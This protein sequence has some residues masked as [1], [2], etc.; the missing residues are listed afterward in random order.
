M[1]PY[2][3]NRVCS[4]ERRSQ[5]LH[6]RHAP[7]Q[8]SHSDLQRPRCRS[9]VGRLLSY[10]YRARHWLLRPN[11]SYLGLRQR[12]SLARRLPHQAHATHLLH[13]LLHGRAFRTQ[14]FRRRQPSYLEGQSQRKARLAQRKGD[15]SQRILGEPSE[16]VE[17]CRRRFQDREAEARAKG[18]QA[19]TEAQDHH[20]R[21]KKNKEENRRKHSKAGDKKP[22]AA[23]KEAILSQKIESL[24]APLSVTFP[25]LHLSRVCISSLPLVLVSHQNHEFS[26]LV[27][28][29][30]TDCV[31]HCLVRFDRSKTRNGI[32]TFRQQDHGRRTIETPND[33]RT[34]A[35]F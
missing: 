10:R 16:E 30:C 1:E 22:K 12:Q 24:S 31:C 7:P 25:S 32:P 21:C 9:H 5:R 26:I 28:P 35:T 34:K 3:A 27:L 19:G 14:R 23:R 29:L 11:A 15:G 4:S 13:L 17:R 33:E 20:D 2:R 8:F 18:H 6:L